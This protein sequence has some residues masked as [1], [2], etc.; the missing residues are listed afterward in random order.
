[1]GDDARV[2]QAAAQDALPAAV[3]SAVTCSS[4]QRSQVCLQ[5]L[6]STCRRWPQEGIPQGD[7]EGVAQA[8]QDAHLTQHTDLF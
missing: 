3:V 5:A 1:M 8:A 4:L 2:A 6:C 7:D